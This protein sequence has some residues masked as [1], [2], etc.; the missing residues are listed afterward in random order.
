M[1]RGA[2]SVEYERA[3]NLTSSVVVGQE[4]GLAGL[5]GRRRRC[6]ARAFKLTASHNPRGLHI[7]KGTSRTRDC[8]SVDGIN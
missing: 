3:G 1:W 2:G 5:A 7:G 4:P 8:A 6:L